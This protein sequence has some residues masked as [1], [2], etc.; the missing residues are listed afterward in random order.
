LSLSVP[1]DVN[2]ISFGLAEPISFDTDERA[3]SM[4]S[5]AGFPAACAEDG[6]PKTS[7]AAVI[8]AITDGA[9]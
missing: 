3:A 4:I 2:T 8:V 9:S 7:N 6:L 5:L 1:P